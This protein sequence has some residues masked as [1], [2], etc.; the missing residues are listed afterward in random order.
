MRPAGCRAVKVNT[1]MCRKQVLFYLI[2]QK[3]VKF[4]E[5]TIVHLPQNLHVKKS[6]LLIN[7]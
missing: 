6:T 3:E 5:Y 4:F 7:H 1:M 2:Y